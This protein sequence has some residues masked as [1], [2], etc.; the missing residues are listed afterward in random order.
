MSTRQVRDGDG[1]P[2]NAGDMIHFSYG[3]PPVGVLARLEARNGRLWVI[4]PPPHKPSKCSL[5]QLRRAVG[6]FRKVVAL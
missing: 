2:V 5:S 3:I 4:V 6:Y 1:K